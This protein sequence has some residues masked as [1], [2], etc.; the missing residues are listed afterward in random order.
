MYLN[1]TFYFQRQDPPCEFVLISEDLTL[2]ATDINNVDQDKFLTYLSDP[3]YLNYKI[4]IP[5]QYLYTDADPTT[6][7][8]G[9]LV[10]NTNDNMVNGDGVGYYQWNGSEWNKTVFTLDSVGSGALDLLNY[11]G[12]APLNVEVTLADYIGENELGKRD[13]AGGCIDLSILEENTLD[14]VC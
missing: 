4:I 2:G 3:T 5:S 13:I 10:Y 9:F 6:E 12:A 1:K 11:N 8:S 14:N 7:D